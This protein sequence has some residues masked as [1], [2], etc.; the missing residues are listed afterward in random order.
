MI[1][2]VNDTHWPLPARGE[3]SDSHNVL[4]VDG[5]PASGT[6]IGADG[7]PLSANNF[8]T[9]VRARLPR[10]PT[11]NLTSASSSSVTGAAVAP[12]TLSLGTSATL[13]ST[14]IG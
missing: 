2:P 1:E 12:R 9:A 8:S 13:S 10:G 7:T 11:I 14:V 3:R 6:E 5:Q 4:D